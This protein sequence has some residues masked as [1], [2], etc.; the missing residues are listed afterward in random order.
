MKA[1]TKTEKEV[2]R[3]SAK[4]PARTAYQE[5]YLMRHT[6]ERTAYQ[7]KKYVWCA[8]CG[9]V[10]PH[11][12]KVCP[13]CGKLKITPS[14]RTQKTEKRYCTIMTTCKGYQVARHFIVTRIAKKGTPTRH[15][16]EEVVQEWID[17][18]GKRTIMACNK[19]MFGRDFNPYTPMTIKHP[20]YKWGYRFDDYAIYGYATRF[21]RI[22]PTLKRNGMTTKDIGVT[23]SLL[24]KALLTDNFAEMLI[25]TGQHSIL[26]NHI[27]AGMEAY[28]PQIR[29]CNRNHYIIKDASMWQDYLR[30]LEHYG[31]DTHNAHYI[32]PADLKTAHDQLV[33]RRRRE[34]ERR[35]REIQRE[36]REK[37]IKE[38][39]KAEKLYRR[40]HEKYLAIYFGN[41]DI[42][43]SVAQSVEDIRQEGEHMHHCVYAC[44]YYKKKDTLILF[45]RDKRTGARLETIEINLK[46]FSVVQSR[47]VC[48]KLT[49]QHDKIVSLCNDNMHLLRAVA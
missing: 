8:S 4:L 20:Y 12:A 40:M 19:G 48:N 23:P 37:D 10:L 17:A 7:T 15:Y 6:F 47:G 44:G 42:A 2:E 33:E 16:F 43:I 29:I 9:E 36:R 30:L 13:H 38:A 31:M 3:L 27:K 25:K 5:R 39:K 35:D 22:L 45:A 26:C 41:A 32:C 1:R 21:S 46:T 18:Q 49:E 11:D 28:A 14:R 34:Q 24:A